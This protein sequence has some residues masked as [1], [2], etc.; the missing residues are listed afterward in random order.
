MRSMQIVCWR[1]ICDAYN[2]FYSK[3]VEFHK[4]LVSEQDLNQN[5][6]SYHV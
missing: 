6:L 1:R 3:P 4:T 5:K 2:Y